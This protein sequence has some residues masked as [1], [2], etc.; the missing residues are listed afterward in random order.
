M[1]DPD[2]PIPDDPPDTVTLRALDD[3]AAIDALAF[4]AAIEDPRRLRGDLGRIAL[5]LG[6]L[7][8]A[9]MLAGRLM[10]RDGLSLAE[11][12]E[13][14]AA[15]DDRSAVP[16]PEAESAEPE[17]ATDEPDVDA[18]PEN[19]TVASLNRALGVSVAALPRDYQV[20]FEAFGSFPAS[21]A[22]FDGLH[23]AAHFGAPLATRRGLIALAEYGFIRRDHRDPQ[24]HTMHPVAHA[25]ALAS[26]KKPALDKRV[27]I[28]RC[29]S[30]APISRSAGAVPRR[31]RPAAR[32]PVG[33]YRG[34]NPLFDA[35]RGYLREYRLTLCTAIRRRPCRR[36]TARAIESAPL[37]STGWS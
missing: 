26:E 33:R 4:H 22:P 5:A 28:W 29:S 31:A 18:E 14:L 21:G 10:S 25:R 3:D 32:A 37:T 34:P 23:A 11:L 16:P 7:P 24:L 17:A 12:E 1:P 8:Y 13:A 36:S 20:L 19:P 35:L 9:L 15:E 2:E 6:K 27:R 30:P